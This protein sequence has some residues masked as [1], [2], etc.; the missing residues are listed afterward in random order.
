M[1]AA[2]ALALREAMAAAAER[3]SIAAEYATGFALTFDEGLPALRRALDDGLGPRDATVELF[4]ALLAAVPDTL[5]ARKRGRAA[6]ERVS[7][8][9]SATLAAGGVR[10]AE[11]RAALAAL[12][13]ALRRDGNALNPGTT[14]DLV[15]AVLFVALLEGAL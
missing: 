2:P 8:R 11:G 9:A 15:T 12:D 14:A 1:R 3:D 6:A 5:V 13:A 7:E 10:S 4:L